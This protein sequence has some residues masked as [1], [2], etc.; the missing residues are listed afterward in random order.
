MC[1]KRALS[2]SKLFFFERERFQAG[3]PD[4][5]YFTTRQNLLPFIS[6]DSMKLNDHY[7]PGK[8]G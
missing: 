7:V 2:L 6:T 4:I 1:I 8:A 5:L 3:C